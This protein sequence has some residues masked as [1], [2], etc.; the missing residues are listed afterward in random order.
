VKKAAKGRGR[1]VDEEKEV[2]REVKE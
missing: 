2:K 1:H